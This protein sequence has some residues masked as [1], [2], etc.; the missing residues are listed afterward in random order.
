M[1]HEELQAIVEPLRNLTDLQVH[2]KLGELSLPQH[3]RERVLEV[4]SKRRRRDALNDA[5][6]SDER[7]L[8]KATSDALAAL[9]G[10]KETA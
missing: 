1:T 10:K 7:G 8:D 9:L 3:D 5:I 6:T 4:L 2:Q